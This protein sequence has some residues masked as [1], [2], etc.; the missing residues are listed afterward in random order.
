M[1]MQAGLKEVGKDVT[2][3]KKGDPVILHPIISGTDGTCLNCRR[4]LDQHADDVAFP[5]LNI[6]DVRA[7]PALDSEN[8]IPTAGCVNDKNT[9]LTINIAQ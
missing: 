7:F 6:K 9:E 2:G 3:F 4:G 8:A 1:K 5:G